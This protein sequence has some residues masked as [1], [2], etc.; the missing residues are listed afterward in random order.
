MLDDAAA[1]AARYGGGLLIAETLAAGLDYGRELWFD[2]EANVGRLLARA[3]DDLGIT[4]RV[5]A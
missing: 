4:V 2:S 3:A 5:T 1:L